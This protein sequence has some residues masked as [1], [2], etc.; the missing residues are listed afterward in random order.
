[1]FRLFA[2]VSIF[3]CGGFFYGFNGILFKT[4]HNETLGISFS[5]PSS[6]FLEEKRSLSGERELHE[7]VL[8]ADTPE[9]RLVRYCIG[10]GDI[11]CGQRPDRA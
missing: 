6:Y 4:Y 10:F 9:N 1:V 2:P 8:T 7:I 3:I 11:S 5:Y